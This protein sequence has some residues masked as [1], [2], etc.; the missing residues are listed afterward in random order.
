MYPPRT[1]AP[2]LEI[3]AWKHTTTPA[4]P[5]KPLTLENYEVSRSVAIAPDGEHFLLGTEWWLRYFDREGTPEWKVLAPGAVWAV[6]IARNRHVGIAALSDGTIRWYDLKQ[7]D[8]L[9]AFFPHRDRKRWVLWNPAGF[10]NASDGGDSLIGY[11]LN[12]GQDEAAAFVQVAQLTNLYFRPEL[13]TAYLDGN[14]AAAEAALSEIG[15]IRTVLAQLPPEVEILGPAEVTLDGNVYKVLVRITDRGS[16]I[17]AIRLRLNG[18]PITPRAPPVG[19]GRGS[20]TKPVESSPDT[21]GKAGEL[22]ELEFRP[23][24][25]AKVQT[26]EVA[27][28][29]EG[30]VHKVHSISK[31]QRLTV[32][33]QAGEVPSLHVLAVGINEYRDSRLRLNY[34]VNDARIISDTLVNRRWRYNPGEILVL[35]DEDATLSGIEQAFEHMIQAVEPNDVFVLFLSGHGRTFQGRYH[36]LPSEFIY[37]NNN[38]LA[39]RSVSET[40]LAEWLTGIQANKTLLILDTC[41]AGSALKLTELTSIAKG[42]NQKASVARLM[43]L[44]GRAIIAA[45][46]EQGIALEGFEKH[47]VFS[48]SILEGLR[49]AADNNDGLITVNELAEF[50]LRRMPMLTDQKWGLELFPMQNLHGQAFVITK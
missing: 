42:V 43:R 47:G 32:P 40:R 6:N 7:R 25:S 37:E 49:G 30:L 48:Y 17:G 20:L 15:D 28:E 8:E 18:T 12:Q 24:S 10:F 41:E 14:R 19:H 34:A 33:P 1:E 39:E 35:E 27:V 11:H 29:V 31:P 21:N 9:L 50:V 23:P 45:S 5:G 38:V 36:F 4:L 3:R 46:S 26:H 13:V 2:G 22:F 44:T 16:G